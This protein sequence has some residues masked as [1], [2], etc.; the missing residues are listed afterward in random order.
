MQLRSSFQ[1]VRKHSWVWL[2]PAALSLLGL[3]IS[4]TVGLLPAVKPGI[5]FK[6]V[7]PN[8][9]PTVDS[10]LQVE[11]SDLGVAISPSV[12]LIT[13]FSLVLSAFLSGGWMSGVFSAIRGQ[14]DV[15]SQEQFMER[16]RYFFGRLLGARVLTFVGTLVGVL[17]V[18]LLLGPLALL[19]LLVAMVFTFFWEL[20]IV[21]EDLSLGDG[22][23]RGYQ[24]LRAN[25]GEVFST[26]LPIALGSALFSVPANLIAQSFIGYVAL[27]PVWSFV[28]SAFAVSIC[29]LYDHL[30]QATTPPELLG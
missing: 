26:A 19:M 17:T 3:M 4:L 23:T 20:A 5:N 15:L 28:G 24:L 7:V 21:R 1:V 11:T 6:S 10:I 22:F 14:S 8:G 13:L 12:L 2:L 18:G 27:I 25:L 29:G 9:M 30:V 16:S